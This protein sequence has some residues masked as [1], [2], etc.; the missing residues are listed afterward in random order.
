MTWAIDEM[1]I[2]T[3][4]QTGDATMNAAYFPIWD[5]TRGATG[6]ATWEEICGWPWG[7]A[8]DANRDRTWAATD[9]AVA[10]TGLAVNGVINSHG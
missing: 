6:L 5:R 4:A 7:V 2:M 8:E 10:A 1:N 9:L 3:T